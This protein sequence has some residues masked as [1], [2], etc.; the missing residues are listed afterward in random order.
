MSC[1]IVGG[2]SD[3]PD[4]QIGTSVAKYRA[5]LGLSQTELGDQ[6]EMH[7]QTIGKIEAG[8]RPLKFREASEICRVLGVTLDDLAAGP[9]QA[10]AR[11]AYRQHLAAMAGLRAE[12]KSIAD[13]IASALIGLAYTEGLN[14]VAP[15]DHRV[16]ANTTRHAERW[17]TT[18]W[19]EMLD[20]AIMEVLAATPRVYRAV[21]DVLD[22]DA[23]HEGDVPAGIC[24]MLAA[25]TASV[26]DWH[27][28]IDDP[29]DVDDAAS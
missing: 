7:Q 16:A 19:G 28:G 13:R 1:C 3:L 29:G 11:A 18:G 4:R 14:R 10:G 24:E 12:V 17:L 5:A 15:D 22:G 9:V 25:V 8:T 2:M 23:V 26:T 21:G 27:P 6:V 20:T